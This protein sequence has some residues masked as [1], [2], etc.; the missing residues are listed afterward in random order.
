MT[1]VGAMLWPMERL[2]EGLAAC[3]PAKRRAFGVPRFP[4]GNDA[5]AAT[6]DAWIESVASRIALEV[7]AIEAPYPGLT[8]AL[9]AVGTALLRVSGREKD[10]FLVCLESERNR[11]R[12]LG[13]DHVVRWV[14]IAAIR[15]AIS[16]RIEATA[17]N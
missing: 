5:G 10:M 3:L 15:A 2:G 1:E 14:K 6:V 9:G 17:G 13:P 8:E 4:H 11:L 7:V 16:E 12:L